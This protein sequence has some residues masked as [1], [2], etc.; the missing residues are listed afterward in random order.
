[1]TFEYQQVIHYEGVPT[2]T[3]QNLETDTVVLHHMYSTP[4]DILRKFNFSDFTTGVNL[5][6]DT[7]ED[8]MVRGIFQSGFLS[9]FGNK[10]H[11]M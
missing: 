9:K 6:I 5:N 2:G 3:S 1:M 7:P 11:Q 10:L 4:L 8:V